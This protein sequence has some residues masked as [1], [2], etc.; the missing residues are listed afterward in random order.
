MP[1]FIVYYQVGGNG[2]F[3]EILYKPHGNTPKDSISRE[4]RRHRRGGFRG[5][6]VRIKEDGLCPREHNT[7]LHEPQTH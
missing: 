1:G 5:R 7:I 6:K 2:D 3:E 4:I